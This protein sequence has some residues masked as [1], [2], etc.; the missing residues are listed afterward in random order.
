MNALVMGA[1][2]TGIA[3]VERLRR[4][5]LFAM[6]FLLAGC[7]GGG[8]GGSSSCSVSPQPSL[9]GNPP[10]SATVGL[11]Y[12]ASLDASYNCLL[13]LVCDAV[14]IVQGPA[15]AEAAHDFIFWVP[16][17]AQAGQT[18]QFVVATKADSCGNKVSKSWVVAVN[19]APVVQSFTA[20]KTS[21]QPGENVVLTAVFEGTGVIEPELGPVTSGMPVSTPNIFTDTS[22][23]LTT[24]NNV[25]T[26]V[27]RV[28]DIHVVGPPSI[29]SFNATQT[30]IHPG[31]NS[32]LDW[33]LSGDYTSARIDPPGTDVTSV[34]TLVVRPTATTNYVLTVTGG[35]ATVTSN[36]QVTVIQPTQVAITSFTSK[37]STSVPLGSVSLSAQFA[38]VT[39]LVEQELDGRYSVVAGVSPGEA[40]NV[41]P[42]YRTTRFRLTATNNVGQSVSK[43]LVV[44]LLGPGTFQPSLGQPL[45]PERVGHTATRLLDGRVFIAGGNTTEIFDPISETFTAGPNLLTTNRNYH[46]AVLLRDGRVFMFGGVCSGGFCVIAEIFDPVSG[47]MTFGPTINLIPNYPYEETFALE[48]LQDGR[49]LIWSAGVVLFDPATGTL[50]PRILP[51]QVLL[52]QKATRLADGRVLLT[53]GNKTAAIFTP[54]SDS[55]S[56]AGDAIAYRPGISSVALLNDGRALITGGADLQ[57]TLAE[58]YDPATNRFREVGTQQV[59]SGLG[60]IGNQVSVT[61]MDGTVLVLSNSNPDAEIFDPRTDTFRATGGLLQ[62]HGVGSRLLTVTATLL[63]DGRVLVLGGCPTLPCAAAA[64]LYMP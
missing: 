61:L 63:A 45:H 11:R 19:A 18:F 60:A 34:R 9:T 20:S 27:R 36:A 14:D 26:P 39:G 59:A 1:G 40:I 3:A 43:E 10:T 2:M 7:G 33:T 29:Q 24:S 4:L 57:G 16:S 13:I 51:V 17:S 6:L 28:L 64:E 49:V 21:I 25:G 44:P 38:G 12:E 50:G 54:G 52:P 8:A 32:S 48:V 22:F 41:G 5:W 31:G 56:A 35:S 58:A 46:S 62:T 55:L 15:G 30:S 47:T 53:R 42:L 23:V 37:P